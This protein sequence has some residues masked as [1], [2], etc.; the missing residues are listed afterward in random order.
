M[1]GLCGSFWK[2]HFL[3]TQVHV[4]ARK[5]TEVHNWREHVQLGAAGAETPER[6][7]HW[8]TEGKLHNFGGAERGPGIYFFLARISSNYLKLLRI[9]QKGRNRNWG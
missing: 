8:G 1:C 4:T 5:C 7:N 6:V 9:S 3:C 2:F